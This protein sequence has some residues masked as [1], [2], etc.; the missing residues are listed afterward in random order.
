MEQAQGTLR[1]SGS[2]QRGLFCHLAIEIRRLLGGHRDPSTRSHAIGS[3]KIVLGKFEKL[4]FSGVVH[5]LHADKVFDE[6]VMMLVNKL[7]E[8]KL[9]V[10]GTRYQHFRNAFQTFGYGF[11]K[12][13]IRQSMSAAHG[14]A[15]MVQ[16]RLTAALYI[17]SVVAGSVKAYNHGV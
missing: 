12:A 7:Y 8:L 13:G 16:V 3:Q 9:C 11:E 2:H 17:S 10:S 4:S 15:A 14:T 5:G 1:R 6:F